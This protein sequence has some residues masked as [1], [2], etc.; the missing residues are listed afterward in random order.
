MGLVGMRERAALL[1]GRVEAG[2]IVDGPLAGGWRVTM[3]L[4][5]N[6]RAVPP[7]VTGTGPNEKGR[8]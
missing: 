1:G 6:V 4:P 3:T 7:P 2:P 5:I 8:P